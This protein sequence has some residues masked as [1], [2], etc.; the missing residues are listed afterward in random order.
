MAGI[1]HCKNINNVGKR[2]LYI[3]PNVSFFILKHSEIFS[4]WGFAPDPEAPDPAGGAYFAPPYLPAV[5]IWDQEGIKQSIFGGTTQLN[6]F[7]K[8]GLWLRVGVYI[9]GPSHAC[10]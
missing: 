8:S 1:Y 6:P 3:A 5:L 7:S 9:F 2:D 10:F 4:V